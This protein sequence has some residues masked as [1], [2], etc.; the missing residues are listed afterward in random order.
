M[1]VESNSH[2]NIEQTAISDALKL[3]DSYYE[4]HKKN[5]FL[6][7]SQ[8]FDCAREICSKVEI[9]RLMDQTFWIV[10]NKNQLYFSSQL[11]NPLYFNIS[12][13]FVSP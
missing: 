10:P 4:T 1:S 3:K 5:V 13:N 12:I 11:G 9:V 6:K 2:S 8:K 7:S